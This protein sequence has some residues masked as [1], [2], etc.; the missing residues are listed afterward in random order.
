M[1]QESLAGGI[2]NLLLVFEDYASGFFRG[3]VA[4]LLSGVAGWPFVYAIVAR[5]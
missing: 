4:Y 1:Y 2:E 3:D 5:V